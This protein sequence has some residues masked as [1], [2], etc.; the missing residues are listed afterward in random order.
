M[1]STQERL[2]IVVSKCDTRMSKF[3]KFF[4]KNEYN[5]ISVSPYGDL[6]E[7]YSFGRR[8]V[9]YP[10]WGGLVSESTNFGFFKKYKTSE[11][12]VLAAE[13][14][15]EN[16]NKTVQ[17]LNEM[18]N[19]KYKFGYNYIGVFFSLFNIDLKRKNRYYCSQFVRY[20]LEESQAEGYERLSKIAY[21][22]C[23]L[24]VQEFS[25]IYKGKLENYP[26]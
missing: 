5:H 7:M 26:S 18:L 9:N 19:Q 23:F 10:F 24:D 16:Y 11:V 20:M 25:C 2:Y 8:Y 3:L 17:I 22:A 21:P 15:K 4:T 13:I 1:V 12:I 6:H 14:S